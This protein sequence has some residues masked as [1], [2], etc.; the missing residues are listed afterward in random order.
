[1]KKIILILFLVQL[2][3]AKE[4]DSLFIKNQFSNMLIPALEDLCDACGCAA[5]GGSMGFASML[6][7]NFVGIRYFNQKYK[8]RNG[9][10][11]NSPW[12]EEQYNTTQVWG[13]IPVFKNFQITAIL[14]YHSHYRN[15]EIGNQDISGIGDITML[16]FYQLLKKDSTEV[17]NIVQLGFGIKIPLGKFDIAN[18]SGVV[19]QSY[20]LGTGS[21][22]YPFAIEHIL[23]YKKL[24]LNNSFNFIFKTANKNSYQYGNQ[25]N[26]SSVL[27]YL[28]EK[29]KYS[30]VPQIGIAGEIYDENTQYK[31]SLKNTKGNIIFG[32]L[33]F[34]IGRDQFSLGANVMIPIHQI[35]AS[36]NLEAVQRW[37]INLNFAL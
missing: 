36:G 29:N 22:D 21:W 5:N 33:G 28:I 13:R 23:K 24:G 35:L 25:Y 27:F 7:Q 3:F 37:S 17:K 9:L 6:D 30:I 15:T 18:N 11:T 4:K 14:P 34:E 8:S 26:Y 1:M 2:S 32:K 12:Y 16:L 10:Y 20:Q 31:Q 19:N